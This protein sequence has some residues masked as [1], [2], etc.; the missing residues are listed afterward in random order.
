MAL[1]QGKATDS[2][3]KEMVRKGRARAHARTHARTRKCNAYKHVNV[4]HIN[5]Y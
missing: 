1:R 3:P 2:Q 5:L 4:T